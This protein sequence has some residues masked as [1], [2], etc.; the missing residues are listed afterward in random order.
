MNAQEIVTT[1]QQKLS[2][3]NIAWRAQTVDT[4][5]AG[6]PQTEVKGIATTGMATFDLIKR[7][8]AAGR[9]FVITHEPTFY[10]HTDRPPPGG[11]CD[12]SGQAEIHQ[13]QQPRHLPFSRPRSRASA[14]S[15]R[16]RLRADAGAD[17]VRVAGSAATLTW[18]RRP[19][20]RRLRRT[21]RSA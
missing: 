19:R 2:S 21:S 3:L 14:R 10:N 6:S 1:I 4:F 8:A 18:C 17:A 13:G 11:R 12:L 5:K 20:S 16:R 9:N 7:A 15:A